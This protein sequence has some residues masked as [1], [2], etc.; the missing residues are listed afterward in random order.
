[1][2]FAVDCAVDE[3]LGEIVE[4]YVDDDLAPDMRL[5]ARPDGE[6]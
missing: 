5:S 6:H 4:F 1:M 2:I 3:A